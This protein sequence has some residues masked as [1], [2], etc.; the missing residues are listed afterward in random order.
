MGNAKKLV[1]IGDGETGMIAYEY[2]T[3]DSEYQVV[4][5]C[6]ERE[7]KTKKELY[8]LPVIE[9]EE[10]EN[11]YPANKFMV[12]V[13]VSSGKLNR[14]RQVLYEKVKKAG[15]TCA[16]YISSR[17]FVWNNVEIGENCF[18]LE[19]NTVQP[20]AKIGNNVTLWSG[21]HI[22]HRSVIEDHCF[23]SSHCVVSG[24]CTVGSCTFLGVNCTV[25][26]DVSIASD[27]FIGAGALVQ[28]NTEP[29]ALYQ[30]TQTQLSKVN[31]HR[32]FR[33]KDQ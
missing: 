6:V 29:N 17:A 7:F 23:I 1:I 5:F 16:N 24:F 30:S 27:N 9:L 4:A 19:H 10:L 22:G 20:F 28:K 21:N 15:Y 13:A 2:F 14:N 11:F 18:I 8:E 33:I 3:Q 12:F 31:T 32:L 26:N 25:E